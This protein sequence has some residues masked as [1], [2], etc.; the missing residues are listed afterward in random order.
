MSCIPSTDAEWTAAISK[1]KERVPQRSLSLPPVPLGIPGMIDHTLLKEPIEPEQ[2]DLLCDEAREYG[3]A[4]VCVRLGYVARAAANLQDTPSVGVACVVGFPEG[5]HD[6]Q[7][8]VREAREAVAHGAT[9]LDMVIN[10]PKLKDGGYASVYDDIFA[11]RKAAPEPIILKAI[12]EAS[13]L[14]KDQI[15][16]ATIVSCMAGVDFV[17]TSTGYQGPAT[18]DQVTTMRL[19]AEASGHAHCRV[20]ASGGIR[21]ATDSM[22]MVKA[23]ATRIGTSAG[24]TIVRELDEGEILEQGASHAVY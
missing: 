18:T 24:I 2:I 6:T 12:I 10:Y 15:I 9:E 3:F 21:N 22:R 4:S 5:T 23:G 11:V 13:E 8:K 20:K 1:V 7:S 14:D 16:A 17:K 19:A